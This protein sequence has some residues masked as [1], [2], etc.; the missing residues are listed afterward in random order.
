M[1]RSQPPEGDNHADALK[2][3]GS[4]EH[5]IREQ[6]DQMPRRP[7]DH[8]TRRLE[9]QKDQKDEKDQKDHKDQKD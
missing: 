9:D 6:G 2:T 3:K 8:R 4:E 5:K 7:E 1:A